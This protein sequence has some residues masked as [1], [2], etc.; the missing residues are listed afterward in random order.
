[1]A[2]SA[3]VG[4][5]SAQSP[6]HNDDLD[7]PGVV[8]AIGS[9]EDGIPETN[10]IEE[11]MDEAIRGTAR[12]KGASGAAAIDEDQ[13]EDQEPLQDGDVGDDLFGDEDGEAAEKPA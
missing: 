7:A 5:S 12:R 8:S 11:D 3:A 10:D 13:E 4:V 6:L 2:S 1:M 9:R